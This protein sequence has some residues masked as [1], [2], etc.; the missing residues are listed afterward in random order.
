MKDGI[1]IVFEGGEGSGKSTQ[2]PLLKKWF[3]VK[4]RAVIVTREPGGTEMGEALR[5]LIKY[6]SKDHQPC[7]LAELLLFAAARS[8]H[9]E[10]LIKP[11]LR[12][13]KVVICDRFAD[14]TTVYQGYGR[15]ISLSLINQVH[16][17]T[18]DINP[19]LTI[20][21][22]ITLETMKE[23]LRKRKI[24]TKDRFDTESEAFHKK[25]LNGFKDL[26]ENDELN[27]NN[28][29]IIDANKGVEDIQEQIIKLI[30][31]KMHI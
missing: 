7:D 1:F 19:D 25:I 27:F 12:E 29:H 15:G 13:G 10:R 4:G 20:I 2:I 26:Y 9:A 6:S 17:L 22:D 21:F 18:F 16:R 11:A 23:R 28:R 8:Q 14:S 30:S 31:D 24:N 5:N 3:E